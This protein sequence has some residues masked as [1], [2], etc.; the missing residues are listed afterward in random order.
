ME[1][2]SWWQVATFCHKHEVLDNNGEHLE[3]SEPKS[4]T[5]SRASVSHVVMIQAGG[6][7]RIPEAPHHFQTFLPWASIDLP[8]ISGYRNE[9][10]YAAVHKPPIS[11]TSTSTNQVCPGDQLVGRGAL[12]PG[13]QSRI[14]ERCVCMLAQ[15]PVDILTS[16]SSG[17]YLSSIMV[18]NF[19]QPRKTSF[20][21][22]CPVKK[23]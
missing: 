6:S 20:S 14:S 12:F 5:E 3:P 16:E 8:R 7:S 2:H 23:Y 18:K 13:N 10:K 21:A 9:Q 17:R 19:I 4:K 1:L 15:K 22:K 11:S